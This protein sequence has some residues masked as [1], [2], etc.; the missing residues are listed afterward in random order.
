MDRRMRD[1]FEASKPRSL[2]ARSGDGY[3]DAST[4]QDWTIWQLA[5]RA[6]Q[7]CKS[8]SIVECPM[9]RELTSEEIEF[10]KQV[11]NHSDR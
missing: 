4:N 3:L 10:L 8:S 9:T 6:A 2:L 5:W 7:N 11:F 1:E